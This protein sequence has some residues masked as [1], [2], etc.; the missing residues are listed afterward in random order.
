MAS[1]PWVK[2]CIESKLRVRCQTGA[3]RAG[4]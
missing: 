1:K 4:L 2:L 3:E